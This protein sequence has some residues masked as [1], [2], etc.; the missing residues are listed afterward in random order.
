MAF[1][2]DRYPTYHVD[3][4]LR[5]CCFVFALNLIELVLSVTS[6]TTS[7]GSGLESVKDIT[8]YVV[9]KSTNISLRFLQILKR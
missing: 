9:Y 7:Y 2:R 6:D 8:L 5:N 4:E 3:A 1:S